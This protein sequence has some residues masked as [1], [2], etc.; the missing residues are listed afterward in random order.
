MLRNVDFVKRL[1]DTICQAAQ[2]RQP[3][4]EKWPECILFDLSIIR[5][6]SSLKTA[7]VE[8]RP[9]VLRGTGTVR[10]SDV[11]P[12]ISCAGDYSDVEKRSRL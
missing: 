4:F 10:V 5:K 7:H 12:Q 1:G 8:M 2:V 11:S 9:I 3:H 6:P